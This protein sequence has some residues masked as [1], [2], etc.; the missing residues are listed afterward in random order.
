M[1]VLTMPTINAAGLKWQLLTATQSFTSPLAGNTQR[2]E[3]PG[4]RWMATLTLTN[5]PDTEQRAWMAFQAQMRGAAG[6]C[7]LSP[8]FA[9]PRLGAGGGSPLVNGANQT[10][11]SLILDGAAHSVTGW[12]KAGDYFSFDSGTGRE[13]KILAADSNT[14]S[15]GNVTLTFEPPIRTAPADN[16]AV[17][18]TAPSAIMRLM[19]DN[20][21]IWSIKP[22]VFGDAT[23]QFIESFA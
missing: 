18:I 1:T 16:A 2:R 20:Q 9:F 12:L 5:R 4:S 13:L 8:S 19:D 14:D 3:L 6:D 11:T 22:P 17:E 10:G 7:Y 21:F 15:S 23:I